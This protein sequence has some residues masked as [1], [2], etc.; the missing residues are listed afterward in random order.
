MR[1]EILMQSL[2]DLPLIFIL[3]YYSVS[4]RSFKDIADITTMHCD[5]AQVINEKL[6]PITNIIKATP[7]SRCKLD[8]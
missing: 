5:N 2:H 8:V 7:R 1:Y 3:N 6:L 4:K